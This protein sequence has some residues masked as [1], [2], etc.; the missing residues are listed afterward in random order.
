MLGRKNSFSVFLFSFLFIYL[1]NGTVD[2]VVEERNGEQRYDSHDEDPKHDN[3]KIS[4]VPF[5][6][7]QKQP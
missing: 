3:I 5:L 6:D 2:F 4:S 7:F 1:P